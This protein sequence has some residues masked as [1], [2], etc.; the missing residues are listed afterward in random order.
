M[1]APT[2]VCTEATIGAITGHS[3]ANAHQILETYLVRTYNMAKSAIVKLEDWTREQKAT[4]SE[5]SENDEP[6]PIA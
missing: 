5:L 2:R 6:P 1:L 4:R 3:I